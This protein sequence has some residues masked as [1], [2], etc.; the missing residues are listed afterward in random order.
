MFR[1]VILR[2]PNGFTCSCSLKG[3]IENMEFAPFSQHSEKLSIV[4]NER[5][6]VFRN[7]SSMK[8]DSEY[9]FQGKL[10]IETTKSYLIWECVKINASE[11]RSFMIRN[12]SEHKIKFCVFI[13]TPDFKVILF[14]KTL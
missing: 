9:L 10:P 3:L 11:I 8:S 1:Y 12:K 6:S 13:K 14:K 2:D 4:T 7:V 5:S